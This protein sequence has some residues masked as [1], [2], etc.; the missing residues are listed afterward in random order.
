MEHGRKMIELAKEELDNDS[1][2][3]AAFSQVV[4]SDISAKQVC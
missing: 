4:P 1:E 3:T 2:L